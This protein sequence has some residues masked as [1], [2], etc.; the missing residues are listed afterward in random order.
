MGDRRLSAAS[1]TPPKGQGFAVKIPCVRERVL[2]DGRDEVFLVVWVDSARGVADLI[3]VS[4]CGGLE[5]D[6]PF[7]AIRPVDGDLSPAVE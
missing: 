6:V 5:E 2:I 4:E 1:R 3:P 7:S